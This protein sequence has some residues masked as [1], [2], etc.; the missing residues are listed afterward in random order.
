[1]VCPDGGA[2]GKI[3]ESMVS[4]SL[5]LWTHLCVEAESNTHVSQLSTV[6]LRG[7]QVSAEARQ[8]DC[9]PTVRQEHVSWSCHDD[10]IRHQT[11]THRQEVRSEDC[12]STVTMKTVCLVTTIPSEKS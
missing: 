7:M 9:R 10:G 1:M 3:I 4:P 12:S 5:H 8:R 2:R 11:C 6:A